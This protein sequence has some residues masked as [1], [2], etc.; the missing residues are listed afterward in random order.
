MSTY[1]K[2]KENDFE[3]GLFYRIPV[4]YLTEKYSSASKIS[5]RKLSCQ[6]QKRLFRSLKTGKMFE[7]HRLRQAFF[8]NFAPRQPF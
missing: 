6:E 4:K 2:Q 5:I 3:Q 1:L 8:E 7:N